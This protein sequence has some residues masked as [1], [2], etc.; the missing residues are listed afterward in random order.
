V[1]RWARRAQ[2]VAA[3]SLLGVAVLAFGSPSAFA[4][5]PAP[6]P[7]PTSSSSD[8]INCTSPQVFNANRAACTALTPTVSCV[9]DNGD[10][11]FSAALGFVNPTDSTIESDAG[12]YQNAIYINGNSPDMGQPS[13][14]RPGTS[15]TEFVLD[16]TPIS[17][18]WVEWQ[19]DN[20]TLGFS[21]TNTQTCDQHPVPIMG[22]AVVW[23]ITG[24]A[25]VC[26]LVLWNRRSMLRKEWIRRLSRA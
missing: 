14:F 5:K 20:N 11:T 26:A 2:V 24:G 19:L 1:R 16:W 21:S 13:I 23:G 3:A 6:T 4:A 17:G 22:S 25:A 8:V 9:W 10:G 18:D 12:T 15:T 7:S